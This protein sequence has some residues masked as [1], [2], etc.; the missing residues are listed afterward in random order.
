MNHQAP[1]NELRFALQVHGKLPETLALP[2]SDGLDA[3]TVDAVLKKR[4]LCRASARPTNR[5]GD[6][7]GAKLT[8][9]KIVTPI[10]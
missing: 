2:A 6:L 8:N 5:T 4:A 1:I 7:H 3:D 9:G 10:W